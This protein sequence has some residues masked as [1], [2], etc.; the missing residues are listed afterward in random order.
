MNSDSVSPTATLQS[1]GSNILDELAAP[2]SP[3]VIESLVDGIQEGETVLYLAYGSNMEYSTFSGRRK[4]KPLSKQNV[5]VPSLDLTFDLKGVPY[6]EPRFANVRK[7]ISDIECDRETSPLPGLIGVVYEVTLTDWHRILATEGGGTSYLTIHIPCYPI[8]PPTNIPSKSPITATTLCAPST[9]GRVDRQDKGQPS[10]RYLN[11]LRTGA[12]EHDLP[13]FYQSYLTAL[14]PYK[15]TSI[16]QQIGKWVYFACWAGPLFCVI[17]MSTLL[18]NNEKRGGRPPGWLAA[19]SKGVGELM[20]TTYDIIFKP[21]FGDGEG[22]ST[23]GA[24]SL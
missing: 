19:L 14:K 1:T 7:R 21:L 12:H 15:I 20:W 23:K 3:V 10:L 9:N 2:S 22:D 16:R 6:F 4:V 24:K 18:S 5:W 8:D 11:L 13:A 17:G